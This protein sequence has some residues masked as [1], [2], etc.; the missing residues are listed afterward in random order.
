[1]AGKS[2][3]V[4]LPVI[5]LDDASV[6][7]EMQAGRA[8]QALCVGCELAHK[9]RVPGEGS[10]GEVDIMFVSESPSSWSASN[11]KIFY[12]RGGRIIRK[13]WSELVETDNK[14]GGHL[15]M[16]HMRKWDTYAVQCQVEE[17]REQTATISKGL[18]DRCSVYLRS[19]IK[20]KR[21]K[22]IIAYGAN[23]LKALGYRGDKF[24]EARGRV[25]DM[26]VAGHSCKVVPT[27]S[28]KHLMAKTGLYDLFYKDMA[29]AARIAAGMDDLA[30][31]ISIEELT[32]DYVFPT[33]VEEVRAFCDHVINYVTVDAPPGAP[34]S[35]CAIALDTETNTVNPHR[36]DAKVLCLSVAWDIGKAGAIPLHHKDAPWTP[37][38]LEQVLVE[39]RRLLECPKPKV[40]HHGKFDL[41]FLELRY[42][43]RVNNVAWDT[44]LGE[45][46]LREDMSGAYSLKVLGRSYF[47][48]FSNYADHVHEMAS[49]LTV[50]EVAYHATLEGCKKGKVKKGTEGFD[51]GMTADMGKAELEVYLFG[52][53]KDR[54]KNTLDSGYERVDLDVLLRYAAIDTDLTRRLMRHQFMRMKTENFMAAK[55]L[56]GT[57]AIPGARVLGLMEF[58]GMRVDQPYLNYLETELTRVVAEKE[59][60]LNTFWTEPRE[61]NP[62]STADIGHVLFM[63]GIWNEEL[64]KFEDRQGPWVERNVKSQQWKTDKKTLRAIAEHTGCKFTTA[65]LEHRAAHKALSGFVHDIKLLANYDGYL[66]TNFQQHGTSTGRLSSN[67]LNM[68]NLPPWLAGYNIKKIFLPDD[69]ETEVVVNLDY[70]GAE[71][72]VF[73]A[74]APDPNLIQALREG[75]DVH[76][77]FTQEIFGIPYEEVEAK[78]ESDKKMEAMRKT[79]K[80]VVFGILYG[81]MAR[82]IAETAGISEAYAQ[83]IIDKLFNRF[84]SLKD[85]M[86]AT[87]A[88]I[89]TTGFVETLFFRRRRF[90]LQSVNNFFRGQAERRGKNMKIQSTSSDIVIGQMIEL[91]EHIHEIGGRLLITVHDSI[92][93][94][95]KKKFIPQLSKFLN[96]YCVQRVAEKYP[97]LPVPFTCDISIGPSYGE[98][99]SI[100][101]YIEKNGVTEEPSPETALFYTLDQEATDELREDEEEA[102]EREAVSAAVG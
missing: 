83:E 39:V 84:P 9:E 15:R 26:D 6:R 93:V 99:M 59:A 18:V 75:L 40:F 21:P 100:Q 8:K 81:A 86:D 88:Q 95:C 96:Y 41:K 77:W 89:H 54:R 46:L 76:S 4:S 94:T 12:G 11:K 34:A 30:A 79:V 22:V 66:H 43:L 14:T 57:L 68:Q 74:Y 98:Q 48:Q 27:F 45:H 90:P 47:P 10:G 85:Y 60:V 23:A 55:V 67:N 44:M 53:K 13:A 62:N 73:T 17:G 70:K 25:L 56:M 1:M 102:R 78:K 29:T 5:D 51:E 16:K 52:S 49:A 31:N 65:V 64:Q 71:I 2:K 72:R 36:E 7:P 97:W 24:M 87:V 28:T 58:K 82:K 101:K 50:E 19:A 37:E 33:T 38:E 69:P 61:F 91:A 80:R 42:G 32:K 92:V 3:K 63:K 20:N 35:R